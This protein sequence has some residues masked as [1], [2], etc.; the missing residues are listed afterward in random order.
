MIARLPTR[1]LTSAPVLAALVLVAGFVLGLIVTPRFLPTPRVGA[2]LWDDYI[3]AVA[4]IYQKDGDLAKA[5]ERLAYLPTDDPTRSVAALAAV[6]VP[7]PDLGEG[8]AYA[9]RDLASA[10][11]H[12]TFAPPPASAVNQNM[13][14]DPRAKAMLGLARE[15]STWV[16]IAL[17]ASVWTGANVFLSRRQAR[18]A[19]SH[20]LAPVLPLA[21]PEKKRKALPKIRAPKIGQRPSLALPKRS[22]QTSVTAAEEPIRLNFVYNGGNEPVAEIAPVIEPRTRRLVAGC[23]LNSGPRAADDAEGFLGFAVWVH[24]GDENGA[25]HAVG[26]VTEWADKHSAEVVAAWAKRAHLNEVLVARPGFVTTIA[27][28]RAETALTV[29]EIG[30]TRLGKQKKAAISRLGV[31]LEVSILRPPV[32]TAA[33]GAASQPMD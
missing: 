17:L 28:E 33:E 7:E 24:D 14:T 27:T 3:L 32:K 12:R 21:Q 23:G 13:G 25:S 22:A 18:R 11:T 15:K 10:L 8:A 9:V 2:L 1:H 16:A 4:A 29:T 20:Q 5:Q 6:Y 30:Y 26:L 31:R 19:A